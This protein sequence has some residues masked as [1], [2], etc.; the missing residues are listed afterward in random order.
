MCA[1]PTEE[2]NG[3]AF[4]PARTSSAIWWRF[5]LLA[6]T[7]DENERP[8]RSYCAPRF[9]RPHLRPP[10]C[11][12]RSRALAIPPRAPHRLVLLLSR[13]SAPYTFDHLAPLPGRPERNNVLRRRRPPRFPGR[14]LRC[15]GF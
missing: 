2:G 8:I 6:G 14:P 10:C 1:G 15:M 7:S 3:T 13:G 4:I 12:D 5:D 9:V 11:D